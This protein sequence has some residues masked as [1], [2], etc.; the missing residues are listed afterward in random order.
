MIFQDHQD[1]VIVGT[2]ISIVGQM[3]TESLAWIRC[4]ER[5]FY[6][7]NEPIAA[8]IIRTINAEAEPTSLSKF[9][10]PDVPRRQIYEAMAERLLTSV[11][12]GYMTVAAFYGHPGVFAY[13]AHRAI[14]QARLEGYKAKMLPAVSAEDCLFADLGIDPCTFGCQSLE[15]TDFL[16]TTRPIDTS[17]YL[18]L[19]QISVLGYSTYEP[20]GYDKRALP[21]LIEKLSRLYSPEH[22]VVVYEA[23][24]MFGG[25]ASIQTMPI[26]RLLEAKLSEASTLFIP[27]LAKRILDNDMYNRCLELFSNNPI[28]A[29]NLQH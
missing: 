24:T 15:A 2:G 23:A 17:G 6:A 27:P 29:H 3:T 8:Q 19:W 22:E 18:I 7:V 11:R 5:F 14:A 9:Y 16:L 13:P 21:L 10:I 20:N 28:T 12:A 4:A 1:L 25:C 26:A